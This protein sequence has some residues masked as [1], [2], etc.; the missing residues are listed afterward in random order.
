MLAG[1]WPVVSCLVV[2]LSHFHSVSV[3]G[4]SRSISRPWDVM[5][6]LTGMTN[7]FWFQTCIFSK[8][9]RFTHLLKLCEFF[10]CA[11]LINT[12]TSTPNTILNRLSSLVSPSLLH[13][14]QHC[15]SCQQSMLLGLVWHNTRDSPIYQLCAMQIIAIYKPY[16]GLRRKKKLFWWG[17]RV[18]SGVFH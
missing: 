15:Q 13:W 9:N 18:V 8:C 5:Y 6:F 12:L 14:H 11:I 7:S 3:S 17:L 16:S 10:T 2:T 1:H 4:P